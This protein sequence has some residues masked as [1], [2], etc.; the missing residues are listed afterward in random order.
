MVEIVP[1]VTAE[2]PAEFATQIDR[3]ENLAERLHVDLADG[4][5]VPRRLLGP[6]Q[7][8][9]LEG[10][11]LDLHLMVEDP[12][13]EFETIVALHPSLVIVHAEAKG[14]LMTVFGQL[15]QFGIKPGLAL[16]PETTV[17]QVT[18]LL[19]YVDHLLI[20]TGRNLGS[21]GG[22]FTAAGLA[23]IPEA[24]AINP[25]LEV[26]VDGGIDPESARLAVAAGAQV[27]D[28][29]SFIQSA[30][31]PAAAYAELVK[32]GQTL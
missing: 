15:R 4:Q 19:P 5:F 8:Y 11:P 26:A 6:A 9:G 3:V 29:G 16:L 17:S 28:C 25:K 13:T 18:Q 20:F 22:G 1:T 23:K 30:M 7:I 21:Q 24:L 27:L 31:D 14:D 10:V 32:I 12:M 2:T